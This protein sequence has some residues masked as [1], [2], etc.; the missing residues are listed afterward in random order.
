ML[1]V[2]QLLKAAD[3]L[4]AGRG[5]RERAS[6]VSVGGVKTGFR[7]NWKVPETEY[8]VSPGVQE[9]IFTTQ[10][11]ASKTD[12]KFKQPYT[13]IFRFPL[14]PATGAPYSPGTSTNELPVWVTCSCPAWRYYCEVAVKSQGNSDIIDS[15]GSYPARNNPQMVPTVCKHLFATVKQ[16]MSK[17]ESIGVTASMHTAQDDPVN[18]KSRDPEADVPGRSAT[19]RTTPRNALTAANP[20]SMPQTWM[21]RLMY[22]LFNARKG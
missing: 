16:A 6:T 20:T 8:W 17:R 14:N 1:T 5:L 21:G 3:Q 7:A 19:A 11:S 22:V 18:V 13:T 4:W 15:N 9:V 10:S 12:R 2:G